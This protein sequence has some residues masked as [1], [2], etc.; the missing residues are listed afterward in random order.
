MVGTAVSAL[1]VGLPWTPRPVPA[2]A[3]SAP[4]LSVTNT[5]VR[6]IADELDAVVQD[7]IGNLRPTA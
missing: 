7:W 5:S 1:S 2:P 4:R 6:R 3:L